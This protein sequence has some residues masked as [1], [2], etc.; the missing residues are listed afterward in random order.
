MKKFI[1][2]LA[3]V[4]IL[5]GS[6]FADDE[7]FDEYKKNVM[8][9]NSKVIKVKPKVPNLTEVDTVKTYFLK[10]VRAIDFE[11]YKGNGYSLISTGVYTAEYT[12]TNVVSAHYVAINEI[13]EKSKNSCKGYAKQYNKNQAVGVY[14]N[15]RVAVTPVNG[16]FKVFVYGDFNCFLK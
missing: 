3:V 6:V 8:G 10:T 1:L 14:S 12:S 5:A 2:A 16:Q 9:N 4:S 15:Y 13:E 11:H 7:G